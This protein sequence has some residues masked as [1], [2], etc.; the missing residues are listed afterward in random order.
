MSRRPLQKNG[1]IA[2]P[3]LRQKLEFYLICARLTVTQRREVAF[4]HLPNISTFVPVAVRVTTSPPIEGL[5]CG[6]ETCNSGPI[7]GREN[8]AR[9]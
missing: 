2:A 4:D 5:F 7:S 1:A 9:K 6:M 3:S 8:E